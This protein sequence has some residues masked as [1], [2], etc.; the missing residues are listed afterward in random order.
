VKR[1]TK[2]KR[3]QMMS[4]LFKA[5]HTFFVFNYKN[6][7]V[8]QSVALRKTLRK[9]GSSLAVVKNRLALRALRAEFPA[10]FKTSFRDPTA[11]AGTAADP[12]GLAR[13]LKEFAAQNK[14]L[15]MK[16][17]LVEGQYFPAER[18]EEI[19]K[20]G[21]REQLMGKVGYLMAYPLMQFLRTWQAPLTNVGS[22]LSQL[23]DKK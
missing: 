6:M 21:S 11:I 2:E 4:E 18:F 14:V 15:V 10:E 8:A 12:I 16:G 22:L 23:K 19:V 13:V 17:G 1:E 3:I 5:N 20:L 9:N 7:T